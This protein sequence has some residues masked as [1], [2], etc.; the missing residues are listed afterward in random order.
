MTISMLGA[1]LSAFSG[2][3]GAPPFRQRHRIVGARLAKG[4]CADFQ[5]GEETIMVIMA[6][7]AAFL[8]GIVVGSGLEILVRSRIPS[9]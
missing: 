9:A 7:F 3:F 8:I 2:Q 5:I 4:N 6:L 1:L